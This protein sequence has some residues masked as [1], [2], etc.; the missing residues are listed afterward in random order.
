MSSSSSG[1]ILLSIPEHCLLTES[2]VRNSSI[3]KQ[4]STTGMESYLPLL[5]WYILSEI[6]KADHSY[7]KYW[8]ATLPSVSTCRKYI[9]VCF[10]PPTL[11][12]LHGSMAYPLIVEA[13]LRHSREY[14]ELSTVPEFKYTKE[15][16]LWARALTAT[17]AYSVE[18]GGRTQTLV[19]P[20][21]D[22]FNHCK[23]TEESVWGFSASTRCFTI[24][25]K[26]C[27]GQELRLSYGLKD[28]V[29]LLA[30][31][32]FTLHGNDVL[33]VVIGSTRLS[34]TAET[35]Q[36]ELLAMLCQACGGRSLVPGA[37]GHIPDASI[38]LA[39]D[40]LR[41]HC[42]T[43]VEHFPHSLSHYLDTDGLDYVTA[44]LYESMAG[45]LGLLHRVLELVKD[46]RQCIS[47]GRSTACRYPGSTG[48]P[49]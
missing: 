12:L 3:G 26:V 25:C 27:P 31:H 28:N 16:Y 33:K 14:K 22:M 36:T 13:K 30:T 43:R 41:R 18:M 32:G 6:S 10:D 42:A 1:E 23:T 34:I 35:D 15:Q 9:P 45:E 17:R 7:W 47:L 48:G 24:L 11:E 46:G 44:R 40:M 8:L 29:T 4:Y 39:Q 2:I 37:P 19:V 21:G 5:S 20:F 38:T 49:R